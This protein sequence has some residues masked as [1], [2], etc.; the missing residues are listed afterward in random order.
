MTGPGKEGQ[1]RTEVQSQERNF[2]NL[3]EQR[4]I[5]TNS[6]LCVGLDPDYSNPKFPE[7]IK[8]QFPDDPTAAILELNK[9]IINASSSL[10]CAYKPQSSFY[11]EF[12]S[13]GLDAL[14]NTIVWINKVDPTIPVIWDAKRGDIGNTNKG[15]VKEADLLGADAI[16][17]NPYLGSTF[18]NDLGQIQ[19]DTMKPFLE[20]KN[21]GVIVLAKTSNVDGGEFQD[22]P[23]DLKNLP[24]NY[25]KKFGDMNELREIVGKDI[26]PVYQILAYRV[27]R[28]WN[29]NGNCALVVG[30]TYPEELAEVRKIVG[31]K[32]RILVPAL[33]KSQGG[34]PED[35]VRAFDSRKRGVIANV[36]RDIDFPDVNSGETFAQAVQRKAANWRDAI[37]QYR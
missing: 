22:L 28:Y 12:G 2:N 33:G 17:V 10:A 34:R 5:L 37:N 26:V 18:F 29:V 3:L 30:A 24:E 35:L 8:N 4:Q 25:K 23:V 20:R 36:S 27:S 31:D 7:G 21:K 14:L 13:K 9:Q 1:S 16:T 19:L 11:E 6:V 32:M 15:Y